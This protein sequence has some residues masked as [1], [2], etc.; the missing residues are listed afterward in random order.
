MLSPSSQSP[1]WLTTSYPLS[2]PTAL[3][4]AEWNFED[5]YNATLLDAD[6]LFLDTNSTGVPDSPTFGKR[7]RQEYP[8]SLSHTSDEDNLDLRPQK[9]IVLEEEEPP[10]LGTPE[11]NAKLAEYLN[12][13][14]DS[15][16]RI[17]YVERP[18]ATLERGGE[19]I[20]HEELKGGSTEYKNTRV[21]LADWTMWHNFPTY[22]DIYDFSKST[23][24]LRKNFHQSEIPVM[25]QGPTIFDQRF[26]FNEPATV[27]ENNVYMGMGGFFKRL[28]R[29]LHLASYEEDKQNPSI[30]IGWGKHAK[31]RRKRGFTTFKDPDKVAFWYNGEFAVRS[32][33][34]TDFKC[35]AT[36]IPVLIPGDIKMAGKLRPGCFEKAAGANGVVTKE[37]QWCCNQIHDYMDMHHC[38]YGYVCTEAGGYM[39]RRR[40]G[41]KWGRVDYSP[42]IPLR[43]SNA[44]GLN[45]LMVLWYFHV[46]YALLG[47][48]EGCYLP[49]FYDSCPADLNDVAE[50]KDQEREE[51]ARQREEER[52]EKAFQ[53]DL[54]KHH[55]KEKKETKKPNGSSR[56]VQRF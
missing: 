21:E 9:G 15:L 54:E 10:D 11:A 50:K 56:G 45:F 39:F 1:T 26:K 33:S 48:D 7:K 38:R 46:K 42:F 4:E 51:K 2:A 23:K 19:I 34:E 30:Y 3:T 29:L 18:W 25:Q 41:G 47:E 16:R 5:Q 31:L 52:E 14:R 22:E 13:R 53:K 20:P 55:K 24:L 8:R 28:N 17:F 35:P 37:V 27:C 49:S 12:R 36:E 6:G 44:R 40:G 32:P 43:S